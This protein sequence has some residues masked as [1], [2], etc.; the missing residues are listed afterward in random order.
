M[1]IG[2]LQPFNLQHDFIRQSRIPN[3]HLLLS[4]EGVPRTARS[5][6]PAERRPRSS[7]RF[8]PCMLDSFSY[9]SIS[10]HFCLGPFLFFL[11]QWVTFDMGD[12]FSVAG[13]VVGLTSLSAYRSVRV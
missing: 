2:Y 8:Q 1:I 11:S 5:G 13:T 6:L 12:P 9:Q 7:R 10:H 4:M 3:T